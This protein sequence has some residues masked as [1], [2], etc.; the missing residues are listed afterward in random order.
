MRLSLP[1]CA[2]CGAAI[3]NRTDE[4]CG[5]CGAALPWEA[6]DELLRARV[7]VIP[8]SEA[9]LDAALRRIVRSNEFVRAE[10]EN[11]KRRI[12]LRLRRPGKRHRPERSRAADVSLALGYPIG[13]VLVLSNQT[14]DPIVLG[15]LVLATLALATLWWWFWRGG[16]LVVAR[17]LRRPTNY[18]VGAFAVLGLAPTPR[19]SVRAG[20]SWR[21]ATLRSS[22]GEELRCFAEANLG[23]QPGACGI[24]WL[25]GVQ[26]ERFEC[27]EVIADV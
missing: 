15:V 7:E 3:S 2:E 11:Q 5:F 22:E 24:G 14:F 27:L 21:M 18:S 10:L 12:R 23:L 6:W 20:P 25:R 1:R 8:C 16:K 13:A 4:H 19:D 9:T 26:L 17:R